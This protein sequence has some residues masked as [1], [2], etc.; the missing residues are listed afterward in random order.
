[1][2][3]KQKTERDA[4]CPGKKAKLSISPGSPV[5]GNPGKKLQSSSEEPASG[6]SVEVTLPIK[7]AVLAVE[8]QMAPWITEIVKYL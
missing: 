6:D 4:S 3:A 7:H 8:K 1:M 2:P 5:S